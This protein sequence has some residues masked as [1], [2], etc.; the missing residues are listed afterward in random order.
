MLSIW[1]KF[2]GPVEVDETYIGTKETNKRADKKLK[3]GRGTIGK[4][5]A[6]GMKDRRTT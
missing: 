2:L 4:T 6:V 5:A 3:A 1:P